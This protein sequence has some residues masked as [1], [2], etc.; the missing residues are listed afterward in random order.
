MI[1]G[2]I[3][4]GEVTLR[5]GG[6]EFFQRPFLFMPPAGDFLPLLAESHPLEARKRLLGKSMPS[7]TKEER[8]AGE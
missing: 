2:S 8:T 6:G 1:F 4:L 5:A 3:R 7:E